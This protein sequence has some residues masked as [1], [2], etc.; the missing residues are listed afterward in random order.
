MTLSVIDGN[1]PREVLANQNLAF[2]NYRMPARRNTPNFYDAKTKKPTSRPQGTVVEGT[3]SFNDSD[4]RERPE[5]SAFSKTAGLAL[6]LSVAGL[7]WFRRR[8]RA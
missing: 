5:Q 3:L 8:R 1:F 7:V 4:P 2:A 6:S